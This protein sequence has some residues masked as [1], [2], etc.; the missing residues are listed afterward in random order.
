MG[1][2]SS[3]QFMGAFVGGA[4][5]GWVYGEFGVEIVFLLCAIA[6]GTWV[7]VALFMN[8]PKYLANMLLSL[9]DI[10]ENQGKD[11]VV[12][13]LNISGIE[14]VKLHFEESVAYLKVDNK[15]LDKDELQGLLN[16]WAVA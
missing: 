7:I 2:Y 16:K 14:E 10:G 15:T 13:L 4:A 9:D 8:T 6:T 3:S 11:F 5:G 1:A 12:E